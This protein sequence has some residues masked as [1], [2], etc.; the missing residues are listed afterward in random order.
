MR[1]YKKLKVLAVLTAFI[2]I[3]IAAVKPPARNDFKNLQV[4]PKNI[5]EDTLDKIMDSF[6]NGLGVNCK[7]CHV[8]NKTIH[9]MEFEKDDKPEKDIARLMIRM[10]IDINKK[11]F[12]FEE[13]EETD[14]VK[15]LKPVTCFTCHRKEPRPAVDSLF[16]R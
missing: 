5:H 1:T 13:K 14:T 16:K 11:Y 15:L 7:Y 10:N 6:T 9:K 12:H 4:L 3:G 8:E 2:C